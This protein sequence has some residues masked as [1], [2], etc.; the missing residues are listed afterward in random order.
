M[1]NG[2]DLLIYSDGG[3]RGNP[4][5]SAIGFLICDNKG[6]VILRRGEYIGNHT[7]NQAEYLALIRALEYARNY[8]RGNIHCFLDSELV[9]KQLK[10]EYKVRDRNL[11]S[12][13]SKVKNLEKKFE[14][15]K[16][17]HVPRN[18]GKL[19]LVDR[20]VNKTLDSKLK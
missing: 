2:F 15:L 10:G 1:A 5:P 8:S 3:S 7:N 14:G 16:Y 4:G 20:L 12:L 13:F 9:V 18:T 17:S 19:V 6:K 11:R